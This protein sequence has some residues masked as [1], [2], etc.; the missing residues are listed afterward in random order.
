[1]RLLN[2]LIKSLK[3]RRLFYS[4]TV[5][6]VFAIVYSLIMPAITLEKKTY[7]GLEEHTHTDSCYHITKINICGMEESEGHKHTDSCYTKKDVLVC[8]LEEN[9]DH[10]HT[11][12]C[13]ETEKLLTCGKQEAPGHTHDDSC[14]AEQKELTCGKQEHI[15]SSGCFVER[16][17]E[18][19]PA[20]QAGVDETQQEPKSDPNKEEAKETSA[21]AA[22]EETKAE[23]TSAE[24]TSA[25]ESPAAETIADET[26]GAEESDPAEAESESAAADRT[27]TADG[28]DYH[29]SVYCPAE[30]CI[31][32]DA[33]LEVQEILQ[34]TAAY[35][36]YVSDA[37]EALD[38][39][40]KTVT[41]ARFFDITIVDANGE[42]IE[43]AVPV[44]VTITYDQKT[45]DDDTAE[46]F[47]DEQ[48]SVVHFAEEGA[49]VIDS[50]TTEEE[51]EKTVD[52]SAESFSVYAV[53]GTAV[54]NS[55]E[56]REYTFEDNGYSMKLFVPAEALIPEGTKLEVYEIEPDSEEYLQLL[57]EAWAKLNFDH[58]MYEQE[59]ERVNAAL[60]AEIEDDVVIPDPVPVKNIDGVRFFNISF[61]YNG[62]E[63]EPCAPVQVQISL[64]EGMQL[65]DHY[66]TEIVH[67]GAAGTE[68]ID[69]VDV[70]MDGNSELVGVAYSQD[71][72]SPIGI[73]TVGS[74]G[75]LGAAGG[76]EYPITYKAENGTIGF[77]SDAACT[78]KIT[79]AAQ[80]TTVY[81]KATPDTGYRY[82][83]TTVT[84]VNANP[85]TRV[86]VTRVE[87]NDD[88][89]SFEMPGYA[90]LATGV[91]QPPPK[92]GKDLEPNG[93]GTYTLSLS[94]KGE[95]N[96]VGANT[97]TTKK[98]NV[99]VVMDRSS[100]M[101][102]YGSTTDVYDKYTG[103]YQTG[104]TY[105][106]LVAGEYVPL[107]Y[108]NG[109]YSYVSSHQSTW[110]VY[111]GTRYRTKSGSDDSQYGVTAE[112]FQRIYRHDDKWYLD[113]AY[114]I[115]YS[116]TRYVVTTQNNN[117]FGWDNEVVALTRR[118]DRYYY[119]KPVTSPYNGDIY[120]KETLTRLAGEQR[121]LAVMLQELMGYNDPD[122]E[123]L[124]DVVE[125][126]IISF[127]G[128]RG[129]KRTTKYTDAETL[130][131]TESAWSSDYDTLMAAVNSNGYASGTNWESAMEYAKDTAD[132]IHASQPDE[133][134]YILFLTDGEPQ[135]KDNDAVAPSGMS[136]SNLTAAY[137]PARNILTASYIYPNDY[138]D[139]DLRGR[140]TG[141]KNYLYGVYTYGSTNS[142]GTDSP[143]Q[144][145]LKSLLRYAYT[146]NANSTDTSIVS[147]YYFDAQDNNQLL[148]ALDRFIA[149]VLS[150]LAYGGVD[151]KDGVTL[152]TG[153]AGGVTASTIVAGKAAGLT[154]TVKGQTG[155]TLFT[156]T[157]AGE[158]DHPTV[159][160]NVVG[161]SEPKPGIQMTETITVM[162]DSAPGGTRT[163]TLTYWTY[164]GAP[165]THRMCLATVGEDGMID[166]NLAGIGSLQNKWEYL[167]S[168]IVWPEQEAYDIV[169]DLNNGLGDYTIS[170]VTD[171][172]DQ[173]GNKIYE[174]VTVTDNKT[175]HSYS[176]L[177]RYSDG[178]YAALT[179]YRQE[180]TYNVISKVTTNGTTQYNYGEPST[181]PLEIPDPMQLAGTTIRT[182]KVW[183]DSLDRTQ[184]NKILWG[185]D[186]STSPVSQEYNVDLYLWKADTLEQLNSLISDAEGKASPSG[187]YDKFTLGWNSEKNAYV[188][189]N[190]ETG[191]NQNTYLENGTIAGTATGVWAESAAISP[192][193][194]VTLEKAAAMGQ[195][196]TDTSRIYSF[197]TN[198]LVDGQMQSVTRQYFAID[199]GHY[200][201]LTEPSVEGHFELQEVVYHPMLLNGNLYNLTEDD[202]G[203]P[204]LLPMTSLEAKNTLRGGINITKVVKDQT[205]TVLTTDEL[206]YGEVT[207]TPPEK[208]DSIEDYELH[209]QIVGKVAWY[210]YFDENGNRVF[211]EALIQAGILEDTGRTNEYGRIG[212]AENY[213]G[214]GWFYLWFQDYRT[215]EGIHNAVGTVP[216]TSKYT[217]RFVNMAEG[218]GYSF[219]ETV[220]NG[221]IKSITG[222][223]GS[224]EGN[225]ESN[226]A[227]TN[228][229][230]STKVKL[231]KNANG[232]MEKPLAD[233]WFQVYTDSECT[234]LLKTDALGDEI[235]VTKTLHDVEYTNVLVSGTDGIMLIGDGT[236][237]KG[238]YYL[239]EIKAPDGYVNLSDAVE[240]TVGEDQVTITQGG[241]VHKYT[242]KDE[243]DCYVAGIANN[244]G[245]EL[246]STGGPGTRQIYFPGILFAAFACAGL[247]LRRK[248]GTGASSPSQSD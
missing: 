135:T 63:I 184:L 55:G 98:V 139:A 59:M 243:D 177:V 185:N 91:F 211:D 229:T 203:N 71:T 218:T 246:P 179:N 216:I 161:D 247:L 150:S 206:F 28:A 160:F 224:V 1:M 245:V 17:T 133:D 42:K 173:G 132:A 74:V 188:W 57:G 56:G 19:S 193:L 138:T 153:T 142:N 49:E 67:F 187:Y 131:E 207:L 119:N 147:N 154:Y 93:D 10:T 140:D 171:V 157:A 116:G 159:T 107:I 108:N 204:E 22:A 200:Y 18:N 137:I 194:L 90:V 20:S 191:E 33:V 95:M 26:T 47:F 30:A 127:A 37:E 104:K 222:A 143:G 51:T 151:I 112:G 176:N 117:T 110:T 92:V 244:P 125:A 195:D 124:K 45:K 77:Y 73:L 48:L 24:D 122:I 12:D 88:I 136:L 164:E 100:S 190:P 32:N 158:S 170:D 120:T 41:F 11:D 2:T 152:G 201:Q 81:I 220:T 217:L 148:T 168:F 23:E 54:I 162:D 87:G 238:T 210:G 50:Q 109:N 141:K 80:G 106:G 102:P 178:R 189:Y 64:D 61:I 227:V 53:I 239:K 13:Y 7:C 79:K 228:T 172:L 242:E 155:A 186:Y 118:G 66:G 34:D 248:Y 146:G 78:Q 85:N 60:E 83:A 221:M 72:F 183:E 182:E 115:P 208:T 89:Y 128:T 230:T 180:V 5:I 29:I 101:V 99:I 8:T 165:E 121:A 105:Y 103:E 202:S 3:L 15:H 39:E 6:V 130:G 58:Y 214:S 199:T 62:K 232:V 44:D 52:F 65:Y 82:S 40:G 167:L 175:H 240:L 69:G 181:I 84:D 35:D 169:A 236:L 21:E 192:G 149:A 223:S 205:E 16:N 68:I 134:V 70:R 75:L 114:T 9:A 241:N 144:S 209:G 43:P 129:D 113:Q 196:T 226:I 4:A 14:F 123:E 38:T 213:D 96:E 231:L 237:A 86:K 126:K 198:E 166:W 225:K 111:T 234:H 215:G 31:P 145:N 163:E 36:G 76:E 233:A 197:T 27:L 235:G 25:A 97:D 212:A 174:T 219:D 94:I 46:S 156:V